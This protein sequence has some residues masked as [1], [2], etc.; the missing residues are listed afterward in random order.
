L[1]IKKKSIKNFLFISINNQESSSIEKK[2]TSF[3]FKLISTKFKS[4]VLMKERGC[5]KSEDII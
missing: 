3:I 5:N 2:T 4:S 1:I